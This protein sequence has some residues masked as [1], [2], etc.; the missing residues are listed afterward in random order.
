M[1]ISTRINPPADASA[2]RTTQES[3]SAKTAEPKDEFI[4][5]HNM[6]AIVTGLMAAV[7]GTVILGIPGAIG[8]AGGALGV[9]GAAVGAAAMA[10]ATDFPGLGSPSAP[11]GALS[12]AAFVGCAAG[13]GAVGGVVA[14]AGVALLAGGVSV[15]EHWR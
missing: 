4:S 10:L 1:T 2:R 7:A 3:G 5:N 12:S 6:E 15:I 9:A 13:I 14:C 8:A 11:S